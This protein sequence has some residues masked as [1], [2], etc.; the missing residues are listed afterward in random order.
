M[1][2]A[3]VTVDPL[4]MGWKNL[5]KKKTMSGDDACALQH[6]PQNPENLTISCNVIYCDVVSLVYSLL[7]LV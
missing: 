2:H 5:W 4:N 3:V 6:D 1:R 7:Y